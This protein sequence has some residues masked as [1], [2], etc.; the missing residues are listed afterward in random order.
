[1]VSATENKGECNMNAEELYDHIKTA[2][3]IFGL[4]W[5]DKK[6]VTVSFVEGAVIFEHK[7][8]TYKV[9]V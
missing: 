3:D 8:Q 6:K 9:M 5:R 1:M 4:S 7:K 2:L